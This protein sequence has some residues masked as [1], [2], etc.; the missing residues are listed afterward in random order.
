MHTRCRRATSNTLAP[1]IIASDTIRALSSSL[2][3]RRGSVP[4]ISIIR[5]AMMSH[6]CLPQCRTCG[7]R[8][9]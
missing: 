4:T 1:G 7:L 3:H 5:V 9:T 8:I 2:N 6:R